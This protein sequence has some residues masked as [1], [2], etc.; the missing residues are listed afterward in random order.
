MTYFIRPCGEALRERTGW[1][2]THL[3]RTSK[4][5]VLMKG[6]LVQNGVRGD[7]SDTFLCRKDSNPKIC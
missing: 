2:K 5:L 1:R 7:G 3:N 4:A 6:D